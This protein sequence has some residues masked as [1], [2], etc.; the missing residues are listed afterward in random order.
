M[1]HEHRLNSC[2][3]AGKRLNRFSIKFFLVSAKSSNFSRRDTQD[4]P[5]N[6]LLQRF[7]PQVNRVCRLVSRG[8]HRDGNRLRGVRIENKAE[9]QS[10]PDTLK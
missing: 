3:A 9:R 4:L 6:P 8:Y 7:Q 1:H 5:L 2:C 10:L